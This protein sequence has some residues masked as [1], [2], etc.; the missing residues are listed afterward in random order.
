MTID[1]ERGARGTRSTC[2][3]CSNREMDCTWSCSWRRNR[4]SDRRRE[5][6][7][8]Q[9]WICRRRPG[10]SRV[11]EETL[12]ERR[13]MTSARRIV[14]YQQMPKIRTTAMS[15]FTTFR[16]DWIESRW[17]FVTSPIAETESSTV[18]PW[19]RFSPERT[20]LSPKFNGNA[21]VGDGE[22]HDREN[23]SDKEE[24]PFV[25]ERNKRCSTHS[26]LLRLLLMLFNIV[27]FTTV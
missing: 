19:R 11:A 3:S 15:I 27:D 14:P 26:M 20:G 1:E 22:N 8:N 17:R 16:L 10:W 21:S 5:F 6:L 13:R 7:A 4:R 18:L 24:H 23:V 9:E 2:C 25:S 12:E